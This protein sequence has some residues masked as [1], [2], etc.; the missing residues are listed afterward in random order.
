MC[1]RDDILH[2][3]ECIFIMDSPVPTNSARQADTNADNPNQERNAP[4]A[5]S[6]TSAR[7]RVS[8][9]QGYTAVPR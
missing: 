8:D 5:V 7:R 2:E 6:L 4:L 1:E 9:R 3:R